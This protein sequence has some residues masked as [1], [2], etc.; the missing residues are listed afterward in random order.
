VLNGG[1]RLVGL[2]ERF[3]VHVLHVGLTW[4]ALDVLAVVVA[5][6]HVVAAFVGLVTLLADHGEGTLRGATGKEGEGKKGGAAGEDD[7]SHERHSVWSG[8][9]LRG[10]AAD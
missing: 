6:G 3:G 8:A 4:L 10:W 1:D 9:C 2:D 7:P 5:R